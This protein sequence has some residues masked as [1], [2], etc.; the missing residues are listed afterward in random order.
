MKYDG[1]RLRLRF[2]WIAEAA[3]KN[4]RTRFVIDGLAAGDPRYADIQRALAALPP[5]TVPAIT[6]DGDADGV[7]PA[8]DGSA[9]A[10]K[11]VGHRVHR[12]IPRAGHNLPQEAPEAFV[13]AVMELVR[14]RLG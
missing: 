12:I 6:L 1:Y 2:P 4:R 9:S 7:A 8:T 14:E 3:L 13:D 10:K 5:I 11:F